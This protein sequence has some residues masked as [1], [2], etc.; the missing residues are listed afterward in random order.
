MFPDN[1]ELG[2]AFESMRKA[3]EAS[4]AVFEAF[5][6]NIEQFKIISEQASKS[7]KIVTEG[8]LK[9]RDWLT[10]LDKAG[11][12]PNLGE[13]RSL[14]KLNQYKRLLGMG[15]AI[16]WVPEES[17]IEALLAAKTERERRA[18]V[19]RN[20]G[21]ISQNCLQVLEDISDPKLKN[22]KLHLT[23]AIECVN[24][25]NFRAAQ[26]TASICFDAM[27]DQIIDTSSL[28]K[29]SQISPK[30]ESDG[31]KLTSINDIPIQYVYGALQSQLIIYTLRSFERLQ[32]QTVHIKYGRH[33]SIHSVS[34]RQYSEFNALQAIT[35]TTSL[36]ATTDRLGL[37]WLTQLSGF[38][39]P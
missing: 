25:N 18:A 19:V 17:V 29:Y 27:L 20:K 31:S 39:K 13:T 38:V 14:K 24:D 21:I 30:L 7:L 12:T 16:F 28:K 23:S 26:S 10:N 4:R 8:F 5:Q 6:K 37:G 9:S 15:Y 1:D 35:I 22:L 36:L 11:L 34:A 2:R 32:P 3:A 33:S